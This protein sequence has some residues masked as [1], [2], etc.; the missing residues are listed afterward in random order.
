[1]KVEQKSKKLG[2]YSTDTTKNGARGL[3]SRIKIQKI[4]KMF[5]RRHQKRGARPRK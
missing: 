5:Y 4:E 1:M 2:K 3:E